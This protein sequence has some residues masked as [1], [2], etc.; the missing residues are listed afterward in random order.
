MKFNAEELEEL[1]RPDGGRFSVVSTD[2]AY[3]FCQELAQKHYE[4][5]PVASFLLKKEW[6]KHIF[7]VYAFARI[8]DDIADEIL[9]IPQDIRINMLNSLEMLI[10]SNHISTINN[11]ILRALL[12]TMTDKNIPP[13][14]FQ[15]LITAYKMDIKFKQSETFSDLLD[16]CKYSAEPIGE[17]VLRITDN[18]SEHNIKLSDKICSALQ[19]INFWQ[20][21]SVDLKNNR[22]FI[23]KEFLT[24]YNMDNQDLLERKK[25]HKLNNCLNELYDRTEILL[26]EGAGL[27]NYLHNL[28]IKSEIK[29]T[30]LGGLTILR[31]VKDLQGNILDKRPKLTKRDFLLIF[32]RILFFGI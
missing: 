30:I 14:P 25:T 15:K 4:N 27:V 28:R 24:K 29:A 10:Q 13:E 17:L 2:S 31:K 3:A 18:Y 8:A 5:F 12:I 19:L 11:P 32:M 20:D 7:P 1:T 23:P 22:I 16:Y 26:K 21:F 6:R 9:N